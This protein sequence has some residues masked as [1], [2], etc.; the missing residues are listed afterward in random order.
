M[1]P[2]DSCPLAGGTPTGDSISEVRDCRKGPAHEA[3]T[4]L[5]APS[6]HAEGHILEHTVVG[7]KGKDFFRIV[8][9]GG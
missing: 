2:L 5:F 3:A 9:L 6:D 8:I 1:T 7:K 4:V